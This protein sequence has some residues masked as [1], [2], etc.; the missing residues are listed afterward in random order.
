[1]LA[2]GKTTTP[3]IKPLAAVLFFDPGDKTWTSGPS[4]SQPRTNHQ[5]HTLDDGRVLTLG[6]YTYSP[7]T[8][9]TGRWVTEKSFTMSVYDPSKDAW[10]EVSQRLPT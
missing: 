4:L 10:K 2:G 9:K 3:P 7:D 5:L 1:M 8:E 6:G